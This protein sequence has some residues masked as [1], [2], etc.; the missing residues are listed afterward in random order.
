[1]KSLLLQMHFKCATHKGKIGDFFIHE[2]HQ[3]P[4]NMCKADVSVRKRRI[5]AK[6]SLMGNEVSGKK[7]SACCLPHENQISKNVPLP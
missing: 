3:A 5:V 7:E 4:A 2:G 1:M 6:R